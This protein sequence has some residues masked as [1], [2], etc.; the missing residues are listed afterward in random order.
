[1]NLLQAIVGWSLSVCL[2]APAALLAHEQTPQDLQNSC[3]RAVQGFYSRTSRKARPSYSAVLS[4]ELRQLLKE[5]DDAATRFASEGLVGL[6][7]DPFVNAQDDPGPCKAGKVKPKGAHYVVEVSC[8]QNRDEEP[9]LAPELTYIQGHWVIVNFHYYDY[10]KG[11]PTQHSDLLS[12]LKR[13]RKDWQRLDRERRK[14][15]R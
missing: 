15:S 9:R 13:L 2:A 8:S 14:K 1:M 12:I 5:N 4:R 10:D 3:R 7:F 11:R 6:D